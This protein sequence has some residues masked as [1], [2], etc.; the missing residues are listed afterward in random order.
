MSMLAHTLKGQMGADVFDKT[1][2]TGTYDFTLQ[3]SGS[4]P[5]TE[6]RDLDAWPLLITALPDQLGLK[7]EPAKG[8]IQILSVEHIERP[9]PN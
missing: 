9:S 2:L 6:S 4:V 3:Y 8:T 7:L 1:G 5:G